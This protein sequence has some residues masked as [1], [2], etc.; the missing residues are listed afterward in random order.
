MQ[1]KDLI[2]KEKVRQETTKKFLDDIA[3]GCTELKKITDRF[4]LLNNN[5]VNDTTEQLDIY[6]GQNFK[7]LTDL[8]N[9][10][11]ERCERIVKQIIEIGVRNINASVSEQKKFIKGQTL[12]FSL[13]SWALIMTG[14]FTPLF[15]LYLIA[16]LKRWI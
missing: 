10:A 13:A 12:K 3:D 1:I 5:I 9:K 8:G 7:R 11:G 4:V 16:I 14:C 6:F 2:S 15:L